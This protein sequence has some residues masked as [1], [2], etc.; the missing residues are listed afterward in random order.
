[1]GDKVGEHET[2][3][4]WTHRPGTIGCTWNPTRGCWPVSPGCANCYACRQGA[5]FC[6]T[7]K[8]YDGLVKLT[9]GGPPKWTGE[10]KFIEDKLDEPFSWREPRTVFVDSM[11]DLF[12][13]AFSFEQ[14]A[15]VFAVMAL[16]RRHTFQILTKR[17][18]RALEF[19]TWMGPSP[20]EKLNNAFDKYIKP[21]RSERYWYQTLGLDPY[22]PVFHREVTDCT[23]PLPNV[24]RGFSAE[25]Q[26][27]YDQRLPY[28]LEEPAAVKFVSI[29]PMLGPIDLDLGLCHGCMGSNATSDHY[30]D[31]T[32]PCATQPYCADCGGG[33]EAIEISYG[34]WNQLGSL[35]EGLQWVIVGC[36]SGPGA[37]PCDLDAVRAIVKQCTDDGVAVFVKQLVET[38]DDG[39]REDPREVGYPSGPPPVTPVFAGPGSRRKNRGHGGDVIEGPYLDGKQY[40]EFPTPET[41]ELEDA[42]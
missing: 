26:D 42:A 8:P 19:M 16:N 41:E 30:E 36:E 4:G 23:W 31:E 32:G 28:M 27:C 7:G 35:T 38:V 3:I 10:G 17:S 21:L 12:F 5:R 33:E 40:L 24:W 9:K 39:D 37:R 20:D 18:Q 15:A 1:M 25:N 2:G 14:I 34:W 11:S 6:G 13:E 22:R 29:E